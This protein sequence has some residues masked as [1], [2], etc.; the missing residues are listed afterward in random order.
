MLLLLLLVWLQSFSVLSLLVLPP[1]LAGT[2][3][4]VCL[5]PFNTAAS[6][7]TA[8]SKVLAVV[9]LCWHCRCCFH[10]AFRA[11]RS[12]CCPGALGDADLARAVSILV[13]T[14]DPSL[15]PL[16]TARYELTYFGYDP[17]Y[18]Y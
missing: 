4:A 15:V 12:L 18:Y 17:T 8:A 7:A 6:C 1:F 2:N 9:L 3:D 16:L 10:V 13:P 11:A 5:Y 14:H